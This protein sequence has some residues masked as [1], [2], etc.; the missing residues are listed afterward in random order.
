[1]QKGVTLFQSGT[2]KQQAT[3]FLVVVDIGFNGRNV[4]GDNLSN[5]LSGK[6]NDHAEEQE[7][8]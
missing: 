7:H 2:G 8:L 3:L 5:R 6:D 1:M 4:P